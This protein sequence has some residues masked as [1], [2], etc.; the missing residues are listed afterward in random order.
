MLKCSTCNVN[1]SAKR[2]FVKFN[3]PA[4][5]RTEII[6]CSTCKALSNKYVCEE[7]NFTGP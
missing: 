1:I 5:G 6:R 2:N 4:C 7:C 3:C